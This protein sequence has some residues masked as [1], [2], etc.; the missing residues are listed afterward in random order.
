MYLIYDVGGT[1]VKY[2]LMNEK[3]IILEKN[4]V[5]TPRNKEDFFSTMKEI[6][7]KYQ[8]KPLKGTAFSLPGVIDV[9]NGIVYRGGG[10]PF[11]HEVNVVEEME[12]ITHLPCAI[13]NDGKCAGLAEMWLG[14]AKDKKDAIVM[15]VGSA[16]AGAIIHDRK[17]I[18]GTHLIAGE[19]SNLVI[20]ANR[21]TMDTQ[22]FAYSATYGLRY[23][24]A[25]GK[26]LEFSEVTGEKIYAWAKDG[27]EVAQECL[28]D[29]YFELAVQAYN[30]QYTYDP[31]I[32]L[33]GGG[34]SEEPLF[35]QG[36]QRYV[37]ELSKKRHQFAKPVIDVCKFNNDSNLIG[38]LYHLLS[39]NGKKD[40]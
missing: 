15:V 37:D 8:T 26:N 9:E 27:D 39:K 6:F 32:I 17:V 7:E 34:I 20:N 33:F 16:I 13:E 4:K 19:I 3:G 10:C 35:I 23:K 1:F 31:E 40:D 5:A 30:F 12:T 28:E 25:K 21:K 38:A 24:V 2:A 36:I 14:N 29:M 22:L 11:L 18:H